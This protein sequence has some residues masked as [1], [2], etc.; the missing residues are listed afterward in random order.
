MSASSIQPDP[1]SVGGIA[2]ARFVVTPDPPRLFSIRAARFAALAEGSRLSPYLRFLA[3]IAGIQAALAESLPAPSP[4]PAD[5][6]ALARQNAMPPIDRLAMA[7]SSE[8]RQTLRDFLDRLAALE[9]PAAAA[10]ALA[11]LRDAD[12]KELDRIVANVVADILPAESL[13]QH[14]YVVAAIQIH[15]ARL[16]ATLDHERLAPIRVGVCPACGGRPV[17]SIVT[18]VQDM[19]GVRYAS[20]SCCATSWNEVRV[21]CL[22]CGSTK[23]IGYRA[24]ESG[25]DEATIKAEVCD[26]CFSWT[27][28]LYQNKNPSLEAVADDVGS[29]GLDLLMKDTD[30]HRA[31]FYPYLAGY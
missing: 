5:Q 29:L 21:K 17:A 6:I 8:C 7:G 30:Y 24:V 2:K 23:G 14:L 12:A 9:K 13:A 16:A 4:V 28:I 31:G 1:S 3:G 11:Q 18:S 10:A 20:C 19:E 22:A 25:V 15:A 27:K 26:S